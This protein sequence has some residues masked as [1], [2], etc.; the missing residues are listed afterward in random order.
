MR[1]SI[2]VICLPFVALAQPNESRVTP[3]L[4]GS[5]GEVCTTYNAYGRAGVSNSVTYPGDPACG[6]GS[7]TNALSWHV[8]ASGRIRAPRRSTRSPSSGTSHSPMSVTTT[9]AP[10]VLVAFGTP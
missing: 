1:T 6:P 10:A 8:R 5:G 4:T 9:I 3:E 7:Y 2:L